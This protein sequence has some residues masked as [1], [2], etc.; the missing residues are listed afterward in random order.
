MRS[1]LWLRCSVVGCSG[2][3]IN[4]RATPDFGAGSG[5]VFTTEGQ[6][7]QRSTEV[8]PP[9]PG[10]LESSAAMLLSELIQMQGPLAND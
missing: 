10:L 1:M 6:R 7:T 5:W 2:L 4:Y 9:R 3:R 8:Q